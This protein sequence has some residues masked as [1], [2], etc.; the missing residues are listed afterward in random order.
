MRRNGAI[1]VRMWIKSAKK[2][3]GKE[4]MASLEGKHR[5]GESAEG[6]VEEDEEEDEGG[7]ETRVEMCQRCSAS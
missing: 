7:M 4:E 3:E 2:L 1:D 6:E 5:E